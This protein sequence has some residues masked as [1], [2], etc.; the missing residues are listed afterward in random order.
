M[1][2]DLSAWVKALHSL[3][4]AIARATAAPD[5]ERPDRRLEACS[6]CGAYLKTLDLPALSPFPTSA[7]GD[8]ETTEL[9]IAAMER[10]YRRPPLKEFGKS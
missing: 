9:D 8:L 2:L 7:I 1:A 10:G 5:D 6:A 4:R 3:E